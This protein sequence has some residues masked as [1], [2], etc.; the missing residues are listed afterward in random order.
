M[1]EKCNN[2]T[3]AGLQYVCKIEMLLLRFHTCSSPSL[4][5][6]I[7][8]FT[9]QQAHR[10]ATNVD[11][12]L[13]SLSLY[14]NWKKC[15]LCACISVCICVCVG[16]QVSVCRVNMSWTY[17]VCHDKLPPPTTK[18]K[19][20]IGFWFDEKRKMK[21]FLKR[22]TKTEYKEEEHKKGTL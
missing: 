22:H 18:K 1:T 10:P 8:S 4:S 19:P 16:E 9:S 7:T 21:V 2:Q 3:R 17:G 12:R 14:L 11:F 15:A 13:S 5:H 6:S 20:H